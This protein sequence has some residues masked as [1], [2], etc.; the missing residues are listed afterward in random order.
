M[1]KNST[2]KILWLGTFVLTALL[3]LFAINQKNTDKIQSVNIDIRPLS[4]GE[5]LIDRNDVLLNIE[6]QFG[7]RLKRVAI[8][9]INFDAIEAG[10]EKNPFVKKAEVFVDAN[11]RIFI[12]ID[13]RQ[14]L[15]R[16][17]GDEG[18]DFFVDRSGMKMPLSPHA[19]PRVLVVTGNVPPY[20]INFLSKMQHHPFKKLFQLIETLNQDTLF[21]PLIEQIYID[22]LGVYA[23]SPKVGNQKI[24][25]GANE[26]LDSKLERL[27]LFYQEGLPFEGWNKYKTIN[28]T[29]DG[30]VVCKRV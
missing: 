7:H 30:I 8:G 15:F 21:N 26:N 4:E 25:L 22:E 3:L 11:E 17:K 5:Q 24:L 2:N 27:K 28:L 18:Q 19:T 29:F 13:Q 6:R 12:N 1:K 23:M 16:I 14:P 10:L 20:E 9:N